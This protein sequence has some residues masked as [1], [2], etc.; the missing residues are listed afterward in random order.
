MLGSPDGLIAVL[1]N[2]VFYWY[3]HTEFQD[4][5][6]HAVSEI[7]KGLYDDI[8]LP[9]FPYPPMAELNIAE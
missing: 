8:L 3:T 4:G 1:T 5:W 9:K 6:Y 2:F 7:G